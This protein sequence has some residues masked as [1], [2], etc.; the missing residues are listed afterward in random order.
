MTTKGWSTRSFGA[1][2]TMSVTAS[3]CGLSKGEGLSNEPQSRCIFSDEKGE[4]TCAYI[5]LCY[6]WCLGLGLGLAIGDDTRL[7]CEEW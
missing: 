3:G 6:Y 1:T 4:Y 2:A 7:I 5:V